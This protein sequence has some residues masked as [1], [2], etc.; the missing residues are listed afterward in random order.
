MNFKMKKTSGYSDQ[1]GKI[2]IENLYR[3]FPSQENHKC[4]SLLEKTKNWQGTLILSLIMIVFG[5]IGKKFT[6]QPPFV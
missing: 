1:K 6:I 4:K 5:I 3:S 2:N